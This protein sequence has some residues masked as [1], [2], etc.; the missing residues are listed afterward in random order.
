M[1]SPENIKILDKM[2][3]ELSKM[4]GWKNNP[5]KIKQAYWSLLEDFEKKKGS[6]ASK[7]ERNILR[8]KAG[9]DK[10]LTN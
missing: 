8:E 9:L 10:L 6:R 2:C 4:L 7:V 3:T 1:T 5:I